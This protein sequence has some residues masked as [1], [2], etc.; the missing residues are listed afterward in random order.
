MNLDKPP[1][2][3]IM[4]NRYSGVNSRINRFKNQGSVY[5]VVS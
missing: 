2:V 3:V 1:G 4:L 5:E